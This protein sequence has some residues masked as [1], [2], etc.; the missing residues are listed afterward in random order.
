MSALVHQARLTIQNAL[1]L[2]RPCGI[3]LVMVCPLVV[4]VLPVFAEKVC[5]G[6]Q[7]LWR[8]FHGIL[9]RAQASGGAPAS[10]MFDDCCLWFGC[11]FFVQHVNDCWASA[12]HTMQLQRD[13]VGSIAVVSS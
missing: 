4:L 8:L 11:A 1:M 3:G 13:C 7:R 6:D 5:R 12:G 9:A 2:K 10:Q